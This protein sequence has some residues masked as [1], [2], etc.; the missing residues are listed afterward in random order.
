MASL[1]VR[2]RTD[3]GRCRGGALQ[4]GALQTRRVPA[5]NDDT[6]TERPGTSGFPKGSEWN[7]PR[8]VSVNKLPPRWTARSFPDVE[9]ASSA[10]I[11]LSMAGDGPDRDTERSRSLDG[12]WR[13]HWTPDVASVPTGHHEVDFDDGDWD[14][15][16]V[17]SVWELQGYGNLV[18]APAHLPPALRG[19]RPPSI[20]TAHAPVG[21]YRRTVTLPQGW[22]EMRVTILFGGVSSAMYLWINGSCVGYSQVSRSPAEFDVSDF[23]QPGE[24]TIAV[25]VHR[26]SDGSYLEN[27]D[28]WFFS[29]I[30]RS[31]EL[32][33][34]PLVRLDDVILDSVVDSTSGTAALAVGAR[35]GTGRGATSHVDRL[36][37]SLPAGW[38]VDVAICRDGD[39][40]A[41]GTAAVVDPVDG[42]GYHAAEVVIDAGR[43]ELWT[44]ET[45]VLHDV[46]VSLVDPA[47]AA[48]DVR[49]VRHGFRSV[50]IRG[51][52][53]LV[54]GVAVLLTGVNRHD[55]DPIAGPTMSADRLREDVALIKRANIN[56]VRT[57]HY[58]DDERFHDLCDEVGLYVMDEADLESHA[59]RKR[60]PGDDSLW[61]D[62]CVDRAERLVGRDRNRT[63]VVMWSLGNESG[64]GTNHETM[65]ARVREL[66]ASRPVHYEGDHRA[67]VTDVLSAMYAPPRAVRGVGQ[68]K[69]YWL[70]R[71]AMSEQMWQG[72]RVPPRRLRGVPF[73]LC[74]YAH[75]MGNSLGN[76]DE[77]L[78]IFRTHPNC[79]GG[80][81]WDF[82]DQGLRHVLDDG[83]VMWAR[84]GDLTDELN[85]GAMCG[86]GIV[87]ADRTPHPAYHQAAFVYADVEVGFAGGARGRLTVRNRFAF[88]TLEGTELRWRWAADGSPLTEWATHE[89]SAPAGGTEGVLV[90]RPPPIDDGR[91][92]AIETEVRT[93]VAAS[94]APA[95][96]VMARATLT[97]VESR[98]PAADR[99]PRQAVRDVTPTVVADSDRSIRVA[100]STATFEL[101]CRSGE[102]VSIQVA[103]MELLES[104]IAPNLWRAQVDNEISATL[105]APRLLRRAA[106]NRWRRSCDSRRCTGTAVTTLPNGDVQLT[107]SW[108]VRGG[109]RPFVVRW[110]IDSAG[111][112]RIDASFTPLRDLP[113]MGVTFELREGFDRLCWFGRGPHESMWD[114]KS[115]APL[116]RYDLSIA[117]LTHAY[118]RPQENGNRTDLRWARLYGPHVPSL[119]IADASGEHFEM[120]ARPYRQADL[121]DATHHHLLANRPTTTV[122]VD[123]H[124]RGVGGDT[125]VGLGTS[126]IHRQFRLRPIIPQHLSLLIQPELRES[127]PS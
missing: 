52:R 66:D 32:R 91:E 9:S 64:F 33:V 88:R 37:D 69:G 18:Y 23:V 122:T 93:T 126:N 127:H 41:S 16:A 73:V 30:F 63:C 62:A 98:V 108:R 2:H 20:D 17:P 68:G 117:E 50:E 55:M 35:I 14:E 42:S 123:S 48:V 125:P 86:N 84:G 67:K 27:Q 36:L 83:T 81:I 78:D 29:G 82:A 105:F 28:M 72:L 79:V 43:P 57:S 59:V 74:E 115:G 102:L 3:P 113:R 5:T 112:L 61:T 114:R 49:R 99:I 45:P 24:N 1:G 22:D 53:L 19:G 89:L 8:V 38:R 97:P 77:Y 100:T 11:A 111:G 47:G 21:C 60:V 90:D 7:D 26:W 54:N 87:A 51:D 25:Q 31:V 110:T 71:T 96:H 46:Y 119:L 10:S 39:E 13:F 85:F 109:L 120:T 65:A 124:Q 103:G 118:L 106:V 94:W 80:F 56:A 4:L 75:C 34:E 6:T 95:G 121:A 101:D 70:L 92:L 104:P 76:I 12:P 40:I 58:P 116:G 44:A 107:T 15:I